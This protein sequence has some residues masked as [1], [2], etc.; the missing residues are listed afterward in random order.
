M[1]GIASSTPAGSSHRRSLHAAHAMSAAANGSRT[2]SGM[3]TEPGTVDEPV[4]GAAAGR[5]TPAT[6]RA[7]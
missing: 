2:M 4:A 7:R 1:T 5:T 6:A 3:G